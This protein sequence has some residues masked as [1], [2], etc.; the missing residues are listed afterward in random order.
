MISKQP[1]EGKLP[2]ANNR[3]RSSD[4]ID[5]LIL[6]K[7]TDKPLGVRD[8]SDEID[9]DLAT[10][11]R[12]VHALKENFKIREVRK[13]EYGELGVEAHFNAIVYTVT[14]GEI[15]SAIWV[16]IVQ[17][18]EEYN[19]GTN[20]DVD[21]LLAEFLNVSGISPPLEYWK[22][23]KE[24][25]VRILLNFALKEID[26]DA[27]FHSEISDFTNKAMEVLQSSKK[28]ARLSDE[29]ISKLMDKVSPS[30]GHSDNEYDKKGGFFDFARPIINYYA[31]ALKSGT[32][33]RW[34]RLQWILDHAD[35]NTN[36]L[37][38]LLKNLFY[39]SLPFKHLVEANEG[40]LVRICMLSDEDKDKKDAARFLRGLIS[41]TKQGYEE[42]DARSG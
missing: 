17:K 14:S 25:D 32:N 27:W 4:E 22:H 42:R 23:C 1:F 35:G 3:R 33:K 6:E 2:G 18:I 10:V 13:D 36:V 38:P 28:L 11:L 21:P 29:I 15:H 41:Q 30:N 20:I 26:R 34:E 7:L 5:R 40:R 9:V 37:P 39:K 8:I 16:E 12:H 31:I 19:N 24:E